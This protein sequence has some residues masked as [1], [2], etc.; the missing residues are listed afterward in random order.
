LELCDQDTDIHS[1]ERSRHIND[2]ADTR[3]TA[4][5]SEL[6][7]LEEK[8]PAK[9]FDGMTDPRHATARECDM[10]PSDQPPPQIS[11]AVAL[12]SGQQ[13][14]ME[15]SIGEP[16]A[17]Q[18]QL[19][20]CSNSGALGAYSST[21]PISCADGR[22]FLLASMVGDRAQEFTNGSA[23]FDERGKAI[24]DELVAIVPRVLQVDMMRIINALLVC[25]S[26][27]C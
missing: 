8:E 3:A 6:C 13:A 25:D 11:D 24:L 4:T 7:V 18:S 27:N 26:M 15:I 5:H 22:N 23:V 1:A 21:V 19:L 20:K 10:P 12:A 16:M 14:P 17:R 2:Q 9:I